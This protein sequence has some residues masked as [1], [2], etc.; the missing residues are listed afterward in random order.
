MTDQGKQSKRGRVTLFKQELN[1]NNQIYEYFSAPLEWN[2]PY[3]DAS[4]TIFHWTNQLKC[5]YTDGTLLK[6][7]SLSEIRERIQT[8]TA[9]ALG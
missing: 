8:Q 3:N 7:Q 6:D 1:D 9:S 5:I 4:S 2:S